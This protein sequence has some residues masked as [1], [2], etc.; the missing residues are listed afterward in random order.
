MAGRRAN[1]EGTLFPIRGGGYRAAV[2]FPDGSRKWLR[3]KTRAAVAAK[4]AKAVRERDQGLPAFDERQTLGQFLAHW[5]SNVAEPSV[6][7]STFRGYESK[8]RVH[9]IPDLG[10]VPLVKLTPQRLTA[11]FKAKRD[12]GLSPRS[13]SHLR[14]ILRAEL[15]DVVKW[16]LMNT[17]GHLF[18]A[19]RREA[20]AKMDAVLRARG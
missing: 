6:R 19:T 14:A 9:L 7:A 10:K 3:G 8:S 2:S 13:V 1:G 12:A 17:Y 16:N 18:E 11:Y 20:A 4:L 5:L 15:S